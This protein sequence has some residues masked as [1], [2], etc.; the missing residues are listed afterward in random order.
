MSADHKTEPFEARIESSAFSCDR[1]RVRKLTGVEAI[2]QL[3][4]FELVVVSLDRTGPDAETMAGARVSIVFEREGD[5][6]RRVH[7]LITEVDDHFAADGDVKRYR[8]RV[9]PRAHRMALIDT[10]DVFVDTSVPELIQNKTSAVG[11]SKSLELRLVGN[12]AKREFVAQYDETDLAFVSRLTEHLGISY[13]FEHQDDREVLVFTDHAGGFHR[14]EGAAEVQ[15]RGRGDARGVFELEA[16]RRIVPSYYAVRDY[17]YQKPLLDLTSQHELSQA[18][19][20]GVIED[21]P[22]YRTPEE[23]SALALARAEEQQSN[24][25]VYAGES[26]LPAFTAGARVRIEGHP[27]LDTL[28]LLLV[29]VKH[30]VT[31]VIGQLSGDGDTGARPY[32][33]T[34]KAVPAQHTYRPPRVTPR[35]RI[36]GLVTG[37]VDPGP[38]GGQSYAP[39]DD[40]GRYRVRFLFDTT[41]PG[42]RPVS[43]PVRMIQNFVG[44]NYGT[45][46]PLK[47]GAEVLVGFVNGDPDR[48]VIV[49]A[50]PNPLKPSPVTNKNPAV[51]RIKTV[52]G[53]TIDMVDEA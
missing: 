26:D 39:I 22:G 48:P 33:N 10:Q 18:G 42:S 12:Y 17:D 14:S 11:L 52:S 6:V 47:S 19:P 7:G 1:L 21:G 30:E 40:Q 23:G 28:D 51:N 43:G 38:T 3:F 34:F 27:D 53:I 15:Y 5:E 45:H 20:G 29:E 37:I 8:I 32:R 36:A 13:F 4:S 46:F 50:V 41:P 24:Q 9:A 25:L 31:Q 2:S 16:R 44:E 49:G 35:P